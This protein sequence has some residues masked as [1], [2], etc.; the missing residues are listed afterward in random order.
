VNSVFGIQKMT[1]DIPNSILVSSKTIQA[2][3]NTIESNEITVPENMPKVS[4]LRVFELVSLHKSDPH[5]L[6]PP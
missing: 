5:S 1:R 4:H 6:P 3:R 2:M